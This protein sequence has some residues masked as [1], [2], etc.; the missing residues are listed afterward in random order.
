MAVTIT[1]YNHT[2]KLFANGEVDLTTLR[3]MLLNNHSFD[4]TD[5]DVSG[6]GID[7]DEVDGS[8]W[9]TGGEAIGSAAV[10]VV[11]TSEAMLDGDDISVQASGGA[12]GPADGA[13]IIADDF[14][15]P[16]PVAR[17]LFYIDFGEEQT[18]GEG[19]PFIVTWHANGIA[20]WT[21]PA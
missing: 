6:D 19:T 1:P 20:R 3:L 11:N 2:R 15:S 17:P 7:N 8:G 12:I 18:A 21:A 4:A 9:D 13:V 14:T 16:T 10:T 5:D